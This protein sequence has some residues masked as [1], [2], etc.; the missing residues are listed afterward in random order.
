MW[1]LLAAVV[2]AQAPFSEAWEEPASSDQDSENNGAL[3]DVLDQAVGER[4]DS[5]PELVTPDLPDPTW[6]ALIERAPLT[7]A[8]QIEQPLVV[9]QDE[10][11][12]AAGPDLVLLPDGSV[13]WVEVKILHS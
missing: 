8:T 6:E 4:V 5:A 3:Q 2:F 1:I 7:F 10:Q 11:N 9:G 12:W 13:Y